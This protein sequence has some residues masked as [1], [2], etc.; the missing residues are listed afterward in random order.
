MC[1]RTPAHAVLSHIPIVSHET[2]G[3]SLSQPGCG[4]LSKEAVFN[5]VGHEECG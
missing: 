4:G 1:V 3:G 5:V 2:R